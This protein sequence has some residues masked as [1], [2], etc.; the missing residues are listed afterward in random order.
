VDV[1]NNNV[2]KSHRLDLEVKSHRVL[3]HRSHRAY[4]IT[5]QGL[6]LKCVASRYHSL[7]IRFCVFFENPK[8]QLY[9][10]LKCHVKNVKNVE[11][12]V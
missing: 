11:S 1:F 12:V 5:H 2:A 8:T 3:K 6:P 10:F 9:V 7:R 4:T